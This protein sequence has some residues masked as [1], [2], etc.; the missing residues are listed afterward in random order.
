MWLIE[1]NSDGAGKGSPDHAGCGDIFSDSSG[2]IFGCFS[3]YVG[4]S[5]ALHAEFCAAMLPIE[6]A[7]NK[8]WHKIWLECD[9]MLVIEAFKIMSLFLGL[10]VVDGRIA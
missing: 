7:Y 2:A 3:S 1:Y 9:S 8:G 6:L 5:S 10:F 4:I